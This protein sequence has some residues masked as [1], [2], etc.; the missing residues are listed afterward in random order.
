[1]AERSDGLWPDCDHVKLHVQSLA[2]YDRGASSNR[3]LL[4]MA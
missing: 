2:C 4:R 1:M 3:P